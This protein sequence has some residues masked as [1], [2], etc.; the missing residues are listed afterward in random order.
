MVQK[1]SKPVSQQ[2][3]EAINASGKSRYRICKEI[4]L[5][6]STMSHFMHGQCGLQLSTID[7]LGELLGLRI[8]AD[9]V[10]RK[11]R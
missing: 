11:G 4:E 5:G 9:G 7:R 2:L 10:K 6:E 3:R 8:V 1:K